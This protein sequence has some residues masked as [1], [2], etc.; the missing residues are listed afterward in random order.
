MVYKINGVWRAGK[1]YDLHTTSS[2]YLGVDNYGRDRFENTRSEMGEFLYRL[3]YKQDRSVVQNVIALLDRIKG[4]ET[5]DLILPVPATNKNRPFQPVEV[6]AEALGKHRGVTYRS[7]VLVNTGTEEL[8]GITDPV[9][10]E[11][12]LS[13]AIQI[14]SNETT[15]D[16]NI[17]LVDDLYRSGSTLTVATKILLEQG[18]AKSVCVLTMTKTRSNR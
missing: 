1:A 9:E 13:E 12:K 5:F 18:K 14:T 16:K 2:V 3:K 11:E 6:I 17:L 7:D 4:I 15:R 8:K 10:R